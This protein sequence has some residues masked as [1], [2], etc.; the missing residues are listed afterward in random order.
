[1]ELYGIL[2]VYPVS[3]VNYKIN[4]KSKN[5]H[6]SYVIMDIKNVKRDVNVVERKTC[7]RIKN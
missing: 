6:K 1:M 5:L 2:Y 7:M 3:H 4:K